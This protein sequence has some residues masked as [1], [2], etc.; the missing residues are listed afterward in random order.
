MPLTFST[1]RDW[2]MALAVIAGAKIRLANEYEERRLK[3][4]RI[5][6]ALQA[7]WDAWEAEWADPPT[8]SP[9]TNKRLRRAIQRAFWEQNKVKVTRKEK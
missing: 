3:L 4:E 1:S 9:E 6:K 2:R 5:A 7:S 8:P